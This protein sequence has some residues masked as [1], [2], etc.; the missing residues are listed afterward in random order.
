MST[1][2]VANTISVANAISVVIP[3]WDGGELLRRTLP[4]VLAQ[5]GVAFEVIVVD[6]GSESDETKTLVRKF[7]EEH[8]NLRLVSLKHNAGYTG[9]VNVG[10]QEAQYTLVAVLGNDNVVEPNWLK[11]LLDCW[12][13][14]ICRETGKMIGAVMSQTIVNHQIPYGPCSLNLFGRNIFYTDDTWIKENFLTFYPGGNAFLYDKF[15]YDLPFTEFYYTYQEDVSLGW[16]IQNRESIVIQTHTPYVHSF[17]G[18]TT[19]RKRVRFKSLMLTERNRWINLLTF[20]ES[21]TLLKL[22]WLWFFDFCFSVLVS[23]NRIAKISGLVWVIC[24][25]KLVNSLRVRR[26]IER[27]ID[28]GTVFLYMSPDYFSTASDPF[29][30]SGQIKKSVNR[31]FKIYWALVGLDVGSGLRTNKGQKP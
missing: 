13:D 23:S 14:G 24:N 7:Q 10:A 28:D 9:G 2:P 1:I 18:G 6:N 11:S 12:G 31:I 27:T 26:Q 8:K 25:Y 3:S 20:P 15:T 30:F 19:K 16:R 21:S 5:T 29:S 17:D 22:F 4:S